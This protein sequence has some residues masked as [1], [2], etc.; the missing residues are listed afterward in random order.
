[1]AK[2]RITLPVMKGKTTGFWPDKA[3]C[4]I[5]GKNKVF[6]PHSMAIMSVQ[7][8][9][10]NRKKICSDTNYPTD[11]LDLNFTLAWHGAH[12][13]GLGENREVY[14]TVDVFD[15]QGGCGELY[16]CSTQ[17]LRTFLNTCVDQLEMKVERA[18][19]KTNNE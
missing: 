9:P 4:P 13:G 19:K 11:V 2:K 15:V 3:L 10:M 8:M 5:C 14:T 12:D 1:M 18:L 17:C 7:A 6:E 16:F